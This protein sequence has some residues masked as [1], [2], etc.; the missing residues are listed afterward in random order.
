MSG[1]NGSCKDPEW[2]QISFHYNEIVKEVYIYISLYKRK[3]LNVVTILEDTRDLKFV[4]VNFLQYRLCNGVADKVFQHMKENCVGEMKKRLENYLTQFVRLNV[5][6]HVKFCM[7]EHVRYYKKTIPNERFQSKEYI[8]SVMIKSKHDLKGS[9]LKLYEYRDVAKKIGMDYNTDDP[10]NSVVQMIN[11]IEEYVMPIVRNKCSHLLTV[12]KTIEEELQG[13]F[14]ENNLI[15]LLRFCVVCNVNYV[16]TTVTGETM[17]KNCAFNVIIKNLKI[18]KS[19]V[20]FDSDGSENEDRL[21]VNRTGCRTDAQPGPSRA[22]EGAKRSSDSDRD[23]KRS[24]G[25]DSSSSDSEQEEPSRDPKPMLI[26]VEDKELNAR[27]KE[28]L[29][30]LNEERA[31]AIKKLRDQQAPPEVPRPQ[32][33]DSSSSSSSSGSS[34]SGSSSGSDSDSD[35]E[36][37]KNVSG[38]NIFNCYSRPEFEATGSEIAAEPAPEPFAEPA[39]AEPA[40]EPFAEPADAE[41]AP[42]PFAEPA[43]AEPAPEPFAEP[44]L[45]E[46]VPSPSSCLSLSPGPMQFES[47]DEPATSPGEHKDP[48]PI[49]NSKASSDKSRSPSGSDRAKSPKSG[50]DTPKSSSAVSGKPKPEAKSKSSCD[51]PAGSGVSTSG[52][53]KPKS[54]SADTLSDKAKSSSTVKPKSSSDTL[55]DKAKSSSTVK[56][57]S[58]SDTPSDKAKSSS[59]VKPKSSS[60]KPS[61]KAKSSSSSDKPC[62]KAKSSSMV[63]PKSSPDKHCD[64]AKSSSTVKPKSSP[65]KSPDKAKSSSTVKP[66]SSSAVPDK[67]KHSSDKSRDAA[68][69]PKSS[70]A[71]PDK[72]SDKPSSDGSRSFRPPSES[73]RDQPKSLAQTSPFLA[74]ALARDVD[75]RDLE[76]AVASITGGVQP[77]FYPDPEP[78]APVDYFTLNSAEFAPEPAP[79]PVPEPAPEPSAPVD[80]FTLNSAEFAPE[81]VPE[82]APEPTSRFTSEPALEPVEPALEPVEPALEPVEPALEPVEPALEPGE[83]ALEPGEPALEPGESTAEAASELAVERPAQPAPDLTFDSAVESTFGHKSTVASELAARPAAEL[84][85]APGPELT[86]EHSEPAPQPASKPASEPAAHLTP[87]RD[88]IPLTVK[89]LQSL[90]KSDDEEVVEDIFVKNEDEEDTV[91]VEDI[92]IKNENNELCLVGAPGDYEHKASSSDPSA[93]AEVVDDD[94]EIVSFPENHT[95]KPGVFMMNKRKKSD[96]M[97]VRKRPRYSQP[98]QQQPPPPFPPQF[99]PYSFASPYAASASAHQYPPMY[100]MSPYHLPQPSFVPVPQQFPRYVYAPTALPDHRYAPAEVPDHQEVLD[101]ILTCLG[102]DTETPQN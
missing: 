41:P 100:H 17:C 28:I 98:P 62:D 1:I 77:E 45:E 57:K 2:K 44:A 55:S 82:P 20:D 72:P 53:D 86:P 88:F 92:Y 96:L 40:P 84:A 43:D 18:A 59:T 79:E 9:V 14:M 42:E 56:P 75:E 39:D 99:P 6:E 78:S 19:E 85:A 91:E 97:S 30:Q 5:L 12:C 27:R 48:Q 64:K 93:S 80:Y 83:P 58:S 10:L 31:E 67:P 4:R 71:V 33:S 16:Y 87:D 94:V 70:S 76:A 25:S 13:Y 22:S 26:P 52:Y 102:P 7:E 15:N 47:V 21:I 63:K 34:S 66:K 65:D 61:D 60:D 24:K 50:C 11:R 32:K 49:S 89:P 73:G 51:K 36:C 68:V 69:K 95:A 74:A 23:S 3:K 81:P 38:K 29:A 54:S 35:D 90:M 37:T 101:D 46:S 8:D